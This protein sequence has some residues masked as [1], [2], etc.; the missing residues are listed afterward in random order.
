MI[1]D[2][3]EMI[4]YKCPMINDKGFALITVM[5]IVTSLIS[6]V[7]LAAYVAIS[8]RRDIT[9]WFITDTK[10]LRIKRALF[11]RLADQKGGEFMSCGGLDSECAPC[12]EGSS[13]S[14]FK[15]RIFTIRGYSAK[16]GDSS[17]NNDKCE[18]VYPYRYDSSYGLWAGYRGKSYFHLLPG[19]EAYDPW[20]YDAFGHKLVIKNHCKQDR[21]WMEYFY[22]GNGRTVMNYIHRA[23]YLLKVRDY[24]K[25]PHDRISLELVSKRCGVVVSQTHRDRMWLAGPKKGHPD[26]NIGYSYA[27]G[28][29]TMLLPYETT[30]SGKY[31]LHRFRMGFSPWGNRG[32]GREKIGLIKV[33]I[34]IKEADSWLAVYSTS[35]VVPFTFWCDADRGGNGS[36]DPRRTSPWAYIEEIEYN[37]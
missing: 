26:K 37:G 6:V 7:Y 3:C 25:T 12:A 5:F 18:K 28:S 1:T 36:S 19:D 8:E 24:K 35:V 4:N 17:S 34:R 2:K 10:N 13:S 21:G 22:N 15:R 27:P 32:T 23:Y 29:E 33:V 14:H 11:G 16:K 9:S 20:Y 31:F 30:D